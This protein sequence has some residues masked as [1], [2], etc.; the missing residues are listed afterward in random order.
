MVYIVFNFSSSSASASLPTVAPSFT[1]FSQPLDSFPAMPITSGIL[2]TP[3]APSNDKYGALSDLLSL[4]ELDASSFSLSSTSTNQIFE[5]TFP[6]ATTDSASTF[7]TNFSNSLMSNESQVK[8]PTIFQPN[9]NL[10]NKRSNDDEEEDFGDFIT[11]PSGQNTTTSKPSSTFTTSFPGFA[12]TSPTN[13][14]VMSWHDDGYSNTT[15][16]C[17]AE[18][19]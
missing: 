7:P 3:I 12:T 5:P 11:V 6:S 16:L 13:V 14:D 4:S 9:L 19:Q 10:A 17:L 15:T 2:P 1:P 8:T 18:L